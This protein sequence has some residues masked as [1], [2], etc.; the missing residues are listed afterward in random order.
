MAEP[1]SESTAADM[2]VIEAEIS[3]QRVPP[4]PPQMG[5]IQGLGVPGSFAE[6]EPRMDPV[7]LRAGYGPVDR[8]IKIGDPFF[9]RPAVFGG[10]HAGLS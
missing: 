3:V 2:V 7:S 1:K 4:L 10:H 5:P 6:Q 8:S 9:S